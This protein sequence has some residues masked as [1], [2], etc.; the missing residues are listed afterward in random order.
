M[1]LFMPLHPA[2]V[3]P[4]QQPVDLLASQ[5]QKL[6]AL[7]WPAE[8][9]FGQA[10]VVEHKGI[11]FPEQAL[12]LVPLAVG[13]GIESTVEGVVAQFLFDDGGK[14]AKAF[15]KIDGVA[16]QVYPRHIIGW[17]DRVAHDRQ[18]SS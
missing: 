17:P 1:Q 4:I 5:R 8:F 9:F 16:V 14:A 3:I 13:E 10:L 15:A 12:D 11:V 18:L 2:D 7:A 6:I